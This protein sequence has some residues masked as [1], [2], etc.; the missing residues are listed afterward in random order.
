MVGGGC[1]GLS[2]PKEAGRRGCFTSSSSMVVVAVVV[3]TASAERI[4]QVAAVAA[5]AVVLSG[6][7]QTQT[8]D[9][10]YAAVAVAG[11][12]SPSGSG[13][14]PRERNHHATTVTVGLAGVT[15]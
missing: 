14:S 5:A 12:S 4:Q 2:T 13:R 11:R 8:T 1:R 7:S 6:L 3:A 10:V 15:E 9:Q